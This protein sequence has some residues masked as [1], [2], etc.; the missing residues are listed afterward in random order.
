MW[1]ATPLR[2]ASCFGSPRCRPGR[3]FSRIRGG[4]AAPTPCTD[5]KRIY[6][7]FGSS[8]LVAVNFNGKVQWRREI[9]PFAW[10]VAIGTSPVLYGDTVLILAD[11][12]QPATSRLIA[13][14]KETGVIKW[15]RNRPTANFNHTTPLLVQVS[16]KTQLLI[17]SSGAC[18]VSIPRTGPSCGGHGTLATCRPR[19]MAAVWFTPRVAAAGPASPWTRRVRA[20]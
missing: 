11:G 20:T 18:K 7:L 8:E 16:G 13:I 4:Y 14:D 3:G 15:E 2:T 1:P 9:V 10:D 17:A 12:T 5:G 6:L 19:S